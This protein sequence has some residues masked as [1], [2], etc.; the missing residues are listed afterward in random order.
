LNAPVLVLVNFL[1]RGRMGRL[2]IKWKLVA[3]GDIKYV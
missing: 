1:D 3:V 2:S